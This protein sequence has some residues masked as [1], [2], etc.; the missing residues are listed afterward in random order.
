MG[1]PNTSSQSHRTVIRRVQ[2]FPTFT[3]D[4]YRLANWLTACRVT[5]VAMEA[6]GVIFDFP[7]F[8]ILD[9]RRFQV[10][11][12]NAR[13]VKNL[14]GRK[15][16]VS[17][18][19]WLR[20]LHILGLL[21]GSFRPADGIVA[22]R[23][24]LRTAPPSL[25]AR[26]L[27]QSRPAHA[28]SVGPDESPAPA[29]GQRHYG[30]DRPAHPPGHRGRSA[31]SASA[32]CASRD[33][34]CRASE[35]EIVAQPSPATTAPNTSS[36]FSR[37]SNSS[38][39]I[40]GSSPPAM[41]PSRCTSHNSPPRPRPRRHRCRPRG[42]DKNRAERN[43]ASN[44]ADAF[45]PAHR[46]RPRRRSTSTAD[47]YNALRLLSEIGTDMTRR[48]TDKHFTSW[49]TLAPNNNKIPRV[50]DS[51]VV[52]HRPPRIAPPRSSVSRP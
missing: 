48:P 20:D 14:P 16:D 29:R 32:G 43:P 30:G 25:R 17:D 1:R 31:R 36:Y 37:T 15:S 22:L 35:A 45:A 7:I 52:G 13:H 38:T 8:E 6:T 46:H 33:H 39:S 51:S 3:A 24:H 41:S 9:A 28:K 18:C 44:A 26:Q 10:I 11:L 49:L 47:R 12:V 19:E 34:R 2:S 42:V 50:G 23:G 27:G 5:H 40:S 21:R 4:L